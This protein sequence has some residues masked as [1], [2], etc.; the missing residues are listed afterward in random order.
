MKYLNLASRLFNTPLL[1]DEGYLATFVSAFAGADPQAEL[2]HITMSDGS[3]MTV[4]EALSGSP[5]RAQVVGYQILDNVAV[6]PVSGALV[7]KGAY[8]PTES[9][10]Q[11]YNG[12]LGMFSAAL[13]DPNVEAIVLDIDSHGGEVAGCFEF[14]RL[15]AASRDEKPIAAYVGEHA[16]SAAYAIACSAEQVFIPDTGVIGSIGVLVAH[17]D[18]SE[19]MSADGIKVTLIHAGKH[20]VDGNPFEPLSAAVKENIQ[21]RIDSTRQKFAQLV[22]DNRSMTLG[23]VLATEAQTY[24]GAR[25]VEV[26]LADKVM[27]FNEVIKLMSNKTK[28]VG[29]AIPVGAL[30]EKPSVAPV[31]EQDSPEVLADDQSP[32]LEAVAEA[33]PEPVAAEFT[34]AAMLALCEEALAPNMAAHFIKTAASEEKVISTLASLTELRGKLVA[35]ELSPA[36]VA[37]IEEFIDS[38]AN[39]AAA[40]LQEVAADGPEIRNIISPVGEVAEAK[41]KIDFYDYVD[42]K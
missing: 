11:G 7:N 4:Q 27:S 19:K 1:I 14:C 32:V 34:S 29:A 36:Q 35:A 31:L 13:D 10:M 37:K 42:Q 33:L 15:V 20:K 30:A 5:R 40:I 39:L 26:G 22:A 25:A 28:E 38:P 18:H 6:I 17:Q 23:A 21:E 24:E 9:G 41:S 2:S 8:L 12:I 16:T 3:S